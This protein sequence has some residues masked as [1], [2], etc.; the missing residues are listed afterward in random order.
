[1]AIHIGRRYCIT[2]LG[3]A[4]A[5]PLAARA[6]QQAMP[7]IGCVTSA[8]DSTHL[9]AAF[10]QGLKQTGLVDGQNVAVEYRWA[11]G[12]EDRLPE[13]AADLVRRRVAVIVGHSTAARAA[14]AASSTTP[15]IFVVGTDPVRTGLVANLNRPG[16]NVTGVTF[17]QVDVTAKRL[18]QLHELVPAAQLIGVL[19]DSTLPEH[20]VELRD[21]EAAAKSIGLRVIGVKAGRPSDFNP[22]FATL[23]Q[24]G[25]GALLVG[26]GAFFTSQRH[27][28]AVLS[29]RHVIPSSYSEREFAVAGGLMSYGPSQADAYRRAGVYAGRILKGEKAGDLP[30]EQPTKFELV[31]NLGTA[32]MLGITVPNAMQ[33][34]ADEVIE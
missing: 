11:E 23:V 1:M 18:G 27:R 9:V 30:V 20:D 16:G 34:L 14:K 6:Q 5:W 22:A 21:A 25:V 26:G 19:V 13:L 24:A 7:V 28:L 2:L 8:Y 29:A 33:L 17:T 10:Q 12:Q 32:T 31:I 4:A 3:G 15:I